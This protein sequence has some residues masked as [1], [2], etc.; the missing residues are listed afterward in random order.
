MARLQDNLAATVA[1]ATQAA[2]Q[3]RHTMA[4]LLRGT[5]QRRKQ[6]RPADSR[7]RHDS[8]KGTPM[9][10]PAVGFA[11][12]SNGILIIVPK[13]TLHLTFDEIGRLNRFIASGGDVSNAYL[14]RAAKRAEENNTTPDVEPQ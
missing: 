10:T 3:L 7:P 4:E 14:R 12:K 8:T 13:A 2:Q 6:R 5:Q 11:R 9:S 1:Q